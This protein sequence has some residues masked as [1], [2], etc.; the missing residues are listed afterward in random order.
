MKSA[1]GTV[2]LTSLIV[3][4]SVNDQGDGT[5]TLSRTDGL[6]LSCQPGG[7]LQTRP[8]GTAGPY[9]KCVLDGTLAFFSP[10]SVTAYGFSFALKVPNT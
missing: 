6:V 8:A 3:V 7:A 10:D 4:A 1:L 2:P 9:E 5:V